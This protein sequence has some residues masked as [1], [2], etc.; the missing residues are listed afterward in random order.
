MTGCV[1]LPKPSPW[2]CV[3][4]CVC[5]TKYWK[6]CWKV[7]H[8]KGDQPH[9]RWWQGLSWTADDEW[10][11]YM[12]A[13]ECT[14]ALHNDVLMWGDVRVKTCRSGSTIQSFPITTLDQGSLVKPWTWTS[15]VWKNLNSNNY[16]LSKY[17]TLACSFLQWSTSRP[18]KGQTRREDAVFF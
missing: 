12:S 14:P 7:G 5:F 16:R 9:Y 11:V 17:Q 18:H 6:V 4:E 10:K 13:S 15:W 3:F 2:P 8:F 1:C